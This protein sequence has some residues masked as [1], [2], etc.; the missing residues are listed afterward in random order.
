[1]QEKDILRMSDENNYTLNFIMSQRALME[2][3]RTENNLGKEVEDDNNSP[4]RSME[5]QTKGVGQVVVL[6]EEKSAVEATKK[7]RIEK[8]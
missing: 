8:H 2:Q 5:L 7:R 1:M 4:K 3:E 6:D